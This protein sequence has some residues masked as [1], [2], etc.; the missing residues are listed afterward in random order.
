[1]LPTL[2]IVKPIGY[3]SVT[4]ALHQLTG[5]ADSVP[6]HQSTPLIAIALATALTWSN[7]T[8]AADGRWA[9]CSAPLLAPMA[10]APSATPTDSGA[11]N[12]TADEARVSGS[13]PIYAFSGGV[14]VQK[15]E[16]RVRGESLR[17]DTGAG[18][19]QGDGGV[20]LRQPG[21]LIDAE[22]ARYWL[23]PERGHFEGVSDYRVAAGHLQGSAER[24]VREGPTRSRY[25]GVTLSTCLPE[26]PFWTLRASSADINR[27]TRQGRA[28]NAVL[29][30]GRL[31]VFYTPYLQF[32]VGSER[33]TG[34][35]APTIGRSDSNGTTLSLPWYWNIAPDQ[36]ATITPTSYWK[37]GVLLD[38]EY[39]YLQDWIEGT[40]NASYLPSDDVYGADRWAID[41]THELRLGRSVRGELRQQRTSD[42]AFN[43]D[44]GNEFDYRSAAFM[45]SRAELSWADREVLASIDAQSWQRVDDGPSP[46]ARRPRVQLGYDPI[47]GLGPVQFDIASEYTD[48]YNADA[49]RE[50][51]I[52]YNIA[53]RVSVPINKLAYRFEPAVAFQH[54]GYDL[55][56]ADGDDDSPSASVPIYTA[57]ARVFFERPDTLFQGVYQTLEPR[58][59][60]R[61]VPDRD[62]DQLP[63][64]GSASTT[65]NFS[66]LFRATAFNNDHT[67]QASVGVTSRYIDERTGREYLRASFGQTFFFHDDTERDR[68]DYITELRLSLPRGFEID[69]DYRWDPD[70]A[71]TNKLRTLLRWRGSDQAAV[72]LSLRR[73][74]TDGVTDQNQISASLAVPITAA[75]RGFAGAREDLD[76]RQTLET[77][78]GFEQSGCCHSFRFIVSEERLRNVD[79]GQSS[80]DQTIMFELELKGLGGIG[81]RIRPFLDAEIDGYNPRH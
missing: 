27:D 38:T 77:F 43:D 55:T 17:Y 59:L 9:L 73:E 42:T 53:P 79:P 48:F 64:F 11:V 74:K 65:G 31:P 13:P 81:D 46:Y 67:E 4:E 66:R 26:R 29:S 71:D 61:H 75:W 35:L 54:S 3:P 76:A 36:D 1:M 37:R 56:S 80:L 7:A 8:P 68:S 78:F 6:R 32:P 49:T 50:Q 72:N 41:Q 63:D 19:L 47:Q 24:V 14:R 51:G 33:L 22:R 15:G 62:Q 34:L 52:E 45:E 25:Q 12:V 70:N 16:Q 2:N 44:F 40:V 18:D 30:I 60:Y 39:R 28:R 57:D 58:V 10:D 20:Q 5:T 69:A 21:V 23:A